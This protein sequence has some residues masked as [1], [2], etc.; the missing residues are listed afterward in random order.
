MKNTVKLNESQL[1]KIVAESLNNILSE[2]DW[3]TYA[4]ASK[5]TSG[6]K[7][8]KFS[9]AAVDS[10]NDE[11]S[12]NGFGQDS[13]SLAP[14]NNGTYDMT[15]FDP[16]DGATTRLVNGISSPYGESS[17]DIQYKIG[18]GNY[19][20][21]GNPEDVEQSRYH[22]KCSPES[23]SARDRGNK[24]IRDYMSGNYAYDDEKGWYLKESVKKA[25]KSVLKEYLNKATK[26]M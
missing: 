14:F 8:K 21:L 23:L 6:D 2:V 4:N 16:S 19:E 13:K 5:K 11:F 3:K 17:D 26:V 20:E 12:H 18:D 9:R 25:V 7:S 15:N 10:F 1:R 22:G 24:E